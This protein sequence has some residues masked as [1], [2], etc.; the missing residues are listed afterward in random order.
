MVFRELGI[1]ESVFNSDIVKYAAWLTLPVGN[2]VADDRITN[3]IVLAATYL[4]LRMSG[5]LSLPLGGFKLDSKQSRC[6]LPMLFF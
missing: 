3:S 5:R 6:W 4:S 2:G 1:D